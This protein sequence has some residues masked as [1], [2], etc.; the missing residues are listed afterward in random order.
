MRLTSIISSAVA[1]AALLLVGAAPALAAGGSG[2][3]GGGTG[4]AGGGGGAG[5]SGSG[6]ADAVVPGEILVK[7]RSGDALV[8]LLGKYPLTLVS[9]F[10]S[11]PIFRLQVVGAARVKDV[12]AALALEPSVMIAETNTTHRAPE[13]RKNVAWVV[14]TPQAYAAQWAKMWGKGGPLARAGMV[15]APDEVLAASAKAVSE[16]PSL[17]GAG[18]K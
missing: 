16:M 10:G 12:L 7:L 15:V 18:L 2:F 13:A 14:G 1:A 6:S 11:R 3:G 5:G 4:G 8:P 9:R 17:D